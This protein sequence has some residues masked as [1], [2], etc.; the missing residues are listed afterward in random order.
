MAKAFPAIFG[1]YKTPQKHGGFFTNKQQTGAQ[2]FWTINGIVD[3][4][5]MGVS[6][7]RGTPKWMIYNGT[8]C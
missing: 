3:D 1:M 2:D 7:T 6:K 8:P 5:Y 4:T